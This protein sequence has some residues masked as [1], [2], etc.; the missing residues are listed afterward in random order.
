MPASSLPDD[1]TSA[2]EPAAGLLRVADYRRRVRTAA[3]RALV[4]S[5]EPVL[6]LSRGKNRAPPGPEQLLDPAA[7]CIGPRHL[8]LLAGLDK[9][10]GQAEFVRFGEP[11]G[12]RRAGR[13][14]VAAAALLTF[15]GKQS[16][17][18]L[19]AAHQA[20][21]QLAQIAEPVY[22]APDLRPCNEPAQPAPPEGF[23][24][25]STATLAS[26]AYLGWALRWGPELS[27]LAL[28]LLRDVL[29]RDAWLTEDEQQQDSMVTSELLSQGAM[30]LDE[31]SGELSRDEA[32]IASALAPLRAQRKAERQHLE[33]DLAALSKT[34]S[35]VRAAWDAR[36][37][38]DAHDWPWFAGGPRAG[39]QRVGCMA[40]PLPGR[41]APTLLGHPDRLHAEAAAR[42][43]LGARLHLDWLWR[44]AEPDAPDLTP[45]Q[46]AAREA[47]AT[48]W[49]KVDD[50]GRTLRTIGIA[51]ATL[52][53][54]VES[55]PHGAPRCAVCQRHLPPHN[56]RAYCK[57]HRA[58]QG[59]RVETHRLHAWAVHAGETQERLA[60]SLRESVG[61]DCLEGT[62]AALWLQAGDLGA[63]AR[64]QS[65]GARADLLFRLLDALSHWTG[66]AINDELR[67]R[68]KQVLHQARE[69]KSSTALHPAHFF[70]GYFRTAP[71]KQAAAAPDLHHPLARA[72][73]STTRPASDV[74]L[75]YDWADLVADLLSQRVWAECGGLCAV[76]LRADETAVP[77][78]PQP[79]AQPKLGGRIHDPVR[80]REMLANGSTKTEIAT[81]F[82]VSRSAVTQF[83]A[84]L[85]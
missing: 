10:L 84:R 62:V 64:D 59:Q 8:A 9:A 77:P 50:I 1:P 72:V 85:A 63:V 15:F 70:A 61:L 11:T 31:D 32:A 4:L 29:A 12:K 78:G 45:P 3:A 67:A 40:W 66:A 5:G 23:D 49:S 7:G 60:V 68:S 55:G 35:T 81:E 6:A 33:A 20:L 74:I 42:W 30:I 37:W 13:P 47:A 2:V 83:F 18:L 65:V 25:V 56:P 24:K 21:Q 75:T 51:M 44:I 71:G 54:L 58:R 76:D 22:E 36:P 17:T 80:A 53:E 52:G 39:M 48:A 38:P 28:G 27:T 69:Q 41:V 43:H 19:E 82:C 34:R 57:L 26:P 16:D 14:A 73:G 46:R 79:E